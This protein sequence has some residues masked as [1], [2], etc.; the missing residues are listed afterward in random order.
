MV[1]SPT[2]D[3]GDG[4]P[5][6]PAAE[7]LP[8]AASDALTELLERLELGQFLERIRGLGVTHPAD[9]STLFTED[10]EAQGMTRLQVRQLQRSVQQG[11]PSTSETPASETSESSSGALV[12]RE[13][14]DRLE[15]ASAI[16]GQRTLLKL[17]VQTY[18]Q[19]LVAEKKASS[20]LEQKM[21]KL[22]DEMKTLKKKLEEKDKQPTQPRS[23]EQPQA[24]GISHMPSSSL[25]VSNYDLSREH[26]T[27]WCPW[28]QKARRLCQ[29]VCC[30][31]EF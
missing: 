14:R 29:G 11:W 24:P 16:E 1:P 21:Q 31:L 28:C 7:D 2:G 15:E 26:A 25:L 22:R 12:S 10:F 19:L 23:I 20:E 3:E 9:I 6:P 5:N 27:R 13:E 4:T 17:Q 18:K 8:Q 30:H